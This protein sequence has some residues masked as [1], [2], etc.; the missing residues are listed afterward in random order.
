MSTQH[1]TTIMNLA[2]DPKFNPV[3]GKV[4]TR[5]RKRKEVEPEPELHWRTQAAHNAATPKIEAVMAV[6][7]ENFGSMRMFLRAWNN[8]E[9]YAQTQFFNNGG[10]A[11]MVES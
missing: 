9:L 5:G 1:S 11:E 7:A 3:T 6:I 10:A 4:E 2:H 8:H